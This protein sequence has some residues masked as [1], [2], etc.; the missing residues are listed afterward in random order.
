MDSAQQLLFFAKFQAKSDCDSVYVSV[1]R[2][3]VS[4]TVML[5]ADDCYSSIQILVGIF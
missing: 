2:I 3:L 5:L 4:W 1:P